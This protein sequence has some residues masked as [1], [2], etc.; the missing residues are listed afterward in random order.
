MSSFGQFIMT[1]PSSTTP[2]ATEKQSRIEFYKQVFQESK[3]D[4]NMKWS[5]LTKKYGKDKFPSWVVIYKTYSR[6]FVTGG[7]V[8]DFKRYSEGQ[9]MIR[10]DQPLWLM[11]AEF[12][13]LKYQSGSEK[14][15][16]LTNI[17]KIPASKVIPLAKSCRLGFFVER[18]HTPTF[19]DPGYQ[20][21]V[22]H[23]HKANNDPSS[24]FE[25]PYEKYIMTEE[26]YAMNPQSSRVHD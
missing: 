6:S 19:Y 2:A 17:A 9:K 4:T 23:R 26:Q 25:Q 21:Y 16:A 3:A 11:I 5:D 10:S 14:V 22:E 13:S 18:I 8:G 20:A 12:Q 7:T 15:E 1:T 24:Y